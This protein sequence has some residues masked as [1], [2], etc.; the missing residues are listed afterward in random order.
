VISQGQAARTSKI[1][2][3]ILLLIRSL[4]LV[5]IVLVFSKPAV[6][7]FSNVDVRDAKSVAIVIDNSFSMDYGDN[8][9]TAKSKAE[10]LIEALPDGSFGFVVPLVQTENDTKPEATQDKNKILEDLRNIRLSYSFTDNEARL[11]E[12]LGFLKKAPNEKKEVILFTDLQKNGW[13]R[14]PIQREWLIPVDVTE[15]EEMKNYA[16][17]DVEYEDREDSSEVSVK[18]WNNSK[19]PVKNLLSTVSLGNKEI[20]GFF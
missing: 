19:V 18:V 11:E 17:S 9:E 2:D 16:V 7:S 13:R 4:I 6:F 10:K 3:L 5:L 20:N 12:I 8:F 1:K 14:E 15:G